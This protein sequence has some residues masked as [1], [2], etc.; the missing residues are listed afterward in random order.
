MKVPRQEPGAPPGMRTLA[1]PPGRNPTTL[2]EMPSGVVRKAAESIGLDL[3]AL[4][5]L[6]DCAGP[7]LAGELRRRFLSDLAAAHS[8]LRLAATCMA[9]ER[10]AHVLL[11]LA[12]QAGAGRLQ[13]RAQ[14]A[15]AAARSG[16]APALAAL[17]PGL[18]AGTEALIAVVTAMPLPGGEG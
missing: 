8:G 13:P 10:H 12:G 18:L 3:A 4:Q 7:S 9:A 5:G 17:M 14:Q 1:L 2:P 11:A 16:D 15:L 6:L